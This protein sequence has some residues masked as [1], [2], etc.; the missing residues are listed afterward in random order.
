MKHL[1]VTRFEQQSGGDPA[2]MVRIA[3]AFVGQ[4]QGWREDFLAAKDQPVKLGALL[5]KMK[6]SCHAVTATGAANTCAQAEKTL[7]ISGQPYDT[8]LS[9]MLT[10]IA[11]LEAE[12]SAL[13]NQHDRGDR[14]ATNR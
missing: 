13:I 7:Q 3:Q 14:A 11:E 5:H 1:D 12:L 8:M 10:L 9:N 4:L 6:G 2:L